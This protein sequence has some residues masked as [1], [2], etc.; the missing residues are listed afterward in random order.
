VN[1]IAVYHPTPAPLPEQTSD[2]TLINLWLHGRPHTTVEA[3][4]LEVRRF[5]A[6]VL[7]QPGK[8]FG[9]RPEP[10]SA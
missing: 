6:F 10:R 5:L 8:G 9:P 3:Y 2:Q 4:N 1:Q 7:P